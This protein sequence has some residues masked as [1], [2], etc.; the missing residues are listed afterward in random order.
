MIFIYGYGISIDVKD[1]R[2]AVI[3]H[4]GGSRAAS[5]VQAMRASG[6]FRLKDYT[7]G[8]GLS[9]PLETAERDLKTGTIRE[10]LIIPKDFDENIQVGR[11]AEI[12]IVLDG[13]DSN[14]ALF[15]GR[16]QERIIDR[17]RWTIGPAG[18]PEPVQIRIAFNPDGRSAVPIV[19]G[20]FVI[21]LMVVSA[22][23]TSVAVAR[24][25]ETGA[26]EILSL[27]PLSSSDIIFGKSI[28]YVLVA[29]FDGAVILVL[30]GAWFHVPFRGSL[31]ALA[32]F[33]GIYVISGAALG[34]LISTM[35]ATQREA[36]IAEVL[37]TLLPAFF[38]SGFI[39]PLESL[40]GLLRGLSYFVPA[41]YFLRIVRGV[42][43]KGA[44]FRYFMLEGA[45]LA[46][47]GFGWLGLAVWGFS[48]RR[49]SP[50]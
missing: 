47:F 35:V 8:A 4:S 49:R 38:L 30:A 7:R 3:D 10:I 40:P 16:M 12:G 23:L 32:F 27:S 26:A 2:T 18:F 11:T 19:P 44:E 20:L 24:E 25:K 33:S 22:L 28:P 43:L 21:I 15:I 5:L 6:V 31:P 45:A 13:S 1:V 34:I 14:S 37:T 39:I 46:G 36:M 9:S 42:I 29:L 48:R 50:R 41:T 17:I